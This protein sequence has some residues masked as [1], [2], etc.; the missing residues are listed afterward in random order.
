MKAGFLILA[1][2][3][4]LTSSSSAFD[5][6]PLQDFCV[7]INDT[8]NG[9]MNNVLFI[10]IRSASHFSDNYELEASPRK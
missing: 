5:P 6:S 3:L 8:K 10:M 4:A 7:A 1:A 9:G 2:L